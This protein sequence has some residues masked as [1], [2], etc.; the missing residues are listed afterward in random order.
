MKHVLN[1]SKNNEYHSWVKELKQRY[2][3]SRLKASVEA[4]RSLLRYYWNL[5]KDIAERQY[6]N[7]YGSA[8]YKTLSRDLRSEM[9]DE[10]GFSERNLKNMYD[11]YY[12]YNQL[13][14]NLQQNA[15]NL[16]GENGQ[17]LADD[18]LK[19]LCSNILSP[20]PRALIIDFLAMIVDATWMLHLLTPSALPTHACN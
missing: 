7:T 8:F 10:K 18:L 17:Q 1:I 11:F 19:E 2:L 5:G 4:N 16:T 14:E 15:A 20:H 9:P 3:S 6:A 13:I 12:T